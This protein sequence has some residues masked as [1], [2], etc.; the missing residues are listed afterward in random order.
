MSKVSR[1]LRQIQTQL[2]SG[3]LYIIVNDAFPGWVKV[4]TTANL[5]ERLHTYQTS[6][7][8]RR[9]RIVYSLEHPEFRTAE[10]KIKETMKRFALSIRNE[11]Y[12]V[13]LGVAKSRLEEQLEAYQGLHD[14]IKIS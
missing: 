7:P 13:D 1:N 3:H 5:K 8:F 14:E 9:Y 4:G 2:K 12:E 11:W 10:K 6:D